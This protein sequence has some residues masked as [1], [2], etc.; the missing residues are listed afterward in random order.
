M[1]KK[2]AGSLLV[3]KPVLVGMVEPVVVWVKVTATFSGRIT[4]RAV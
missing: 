2:T 4:A 1:R 3:K